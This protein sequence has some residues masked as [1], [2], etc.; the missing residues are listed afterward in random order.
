M[1]SNK[2]YDILKRI[3][4]LAV[5]FAGIICSLIKMIQNGV[6]VV[7]LVEFIGSAVAQAIGLIIEVSSRSYWSEQKKESEEVNG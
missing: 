2:A 7:T 6:D 3:S 5:P 1:L 4:I